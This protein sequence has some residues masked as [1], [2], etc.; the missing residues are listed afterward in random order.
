VIE[1]AIGAAV[2]V[3]ASAL[4]RA[5]LQRRLDREAY[6]KRSAEELAK[7]MDPRRGVQVGDVLLYLG[8]SLWLSGSIEFD[9]EGRRFTLFRSPEN[10]EVSWVLQLDDEGRELA[11]LSECREI[12]EGSVPVQLRL[13]G[14]L[15]SLERRGRAF[16]KGKGEHL[17]K[18]A[19]KASFAMLSDS[20]GKMAVVIDFEKGERLSLWGDRKERSLLDVLPGGS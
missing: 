10:A 8:E 12:P 2:V 1:L 13:G 19:P 15:L 9:E 3:A 6:A 17:P 18:L 16:A 7:L 20:G 5:V 4:A 11:L 14:R